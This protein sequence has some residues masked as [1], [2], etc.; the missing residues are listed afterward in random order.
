[1]RIL[2][3]CLNTSDKKNCSKIFVVVHSTSITFAISVKTNDSGM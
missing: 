2:L 3:I 1:M